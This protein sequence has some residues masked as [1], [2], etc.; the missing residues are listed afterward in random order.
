QGG[1]ADLGRGLGTEVDTAVDL[2]G[3]H[4][5]GALEVGPDG[6]DL[7]HVEA[8]HAHLVAGPDAAALDEHAAHLVAVL[9]HAQRDD[10]EGD[11]ERDSGGDEG[12]DAEDERVHVGEAGDA[13]AAHGPRSSWKMSSEDAPGGSSVVGWGH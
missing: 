13:D 5:L 12:R 8:R 9:E 7:A 6:G 10:G 11:D 2:P 3:D 1:E 4:D